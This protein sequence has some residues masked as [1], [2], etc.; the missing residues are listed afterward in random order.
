[1]RDRETWRIRDRDE[2]RE[3]TESQTEEADIRGDK[4]MEDGIERC[5]HFSK[6]PWVPRVAQVS[7]PRMVGQA[8]FSLC[9]I[10]GSQSCG[11]ALAADNLE[12]PAVV[13]I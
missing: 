9:P 2:K 5:S 8:L 3:Q 11:G 10:R 4:G 1:M 13:P 12:V 7:E 6:G